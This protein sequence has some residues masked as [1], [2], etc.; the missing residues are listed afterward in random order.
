[1]K[2]T[3][4]DSKARYDDLPYSSYAYRYS[5]PEQL[6]TVASLFG[7]PSPAVP[8]A[9]VLELGCGSGGNLVPIAL[10]NPAS[11]L[12]GVDISGVQIGEGRETIGRLGIDNVTLR[13]ADLLDLSAESLGEFDYIIA[14]GVYSWVPPHVQE[15]LLG[16]MR[17]CLSPT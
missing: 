15:A 6:A 4:Q 13:E 7:L 9:R 5:A 1:M 11:T 14:H 12:V 2:P 3:D 17:R 8:T 16:L 10:R